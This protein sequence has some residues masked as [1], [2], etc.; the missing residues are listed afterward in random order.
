M[1]GRT[2]ASNDTRLLTGLPGRQK[3][4]TLSPRCPKPCGL[5]G[6]IA[7]RENSTV[8]ISLSASLT[9]SKAPMLTPPLVTRMSA[10]SSWLSRASSSLA[11]SSGTMPMRRA[12][13]PASRAA[14]A[15]M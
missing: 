10:R 6:C 5:P 8:P 1:A 12:S 4:G 13:A 15:I 9:T 11:W 7:M 14:A 2:K 3:I